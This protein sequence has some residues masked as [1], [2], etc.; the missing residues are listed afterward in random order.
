MA[1]KPTRRTISPS[2]LLSSQKTNNR[3]TS[4]PP[5]NTRVIQMVKTPYLTVNHSYVD[6]SLVPPDLEYTV[7]PSTIAEMDFHQKLHSMLSRPEF[8]ESVC[9][10]W[11]G[12]AFKIHIPSKFEKSACF[13]YFGHKRYS[14]FLHLL[15]L[16]GYKHQ[17]AMTRDLS[18]VLTLVDTRHTQLMLRGL[19]HLTKFA[20]SAKEFRHLVQDPK[21][22]PDFH[23]IH[24]IAPLPSDSHFG[25]SLTM[26]DVI[27]FCRKGGRSEAAVIRALLSILSTKKDGAE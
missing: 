21:N 24:L 12:R 26:E 3:S 17:P 11:H 15:G 6:Y 9:W 23:L 1:R 22:E 5:V 16:H 2:V 27:Q 4:N 19:P 20:P 8:S 13:E 14:S 10:A 25:K 18:F 7:C